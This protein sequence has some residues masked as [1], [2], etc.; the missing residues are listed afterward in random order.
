MDA[1]T[2][3]VVSYVVPEK[4]SYP[5]SGKTFEFFR[6]VY[7]DLQRLSTAELSM[8]SEIRKDWRNVFNVSKKVEVG[9][10]KGKVPETFLKEGCF[11]LGLDTFA[12]LC[13][14]DICDFKTNTCIVFESLNETPIF[15]SDTI[16]EPKF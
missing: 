4:P 12:L 13:Y 14:I 15:L 16:F 2:C 3:A 1:D 5:F 11:V 10:Y 7:V 8:I 9:I 6:S